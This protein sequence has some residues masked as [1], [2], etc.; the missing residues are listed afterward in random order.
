[1]NLLIDIKIMKII[2]KLNLKKKFLNLRILYKI[3]KIK[4]KNHNKKLNIKKI[5]LKKCLKLMN[6]KKIKCIIIMI[7]WKN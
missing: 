3:T 6:I 4:M 1:M 7:Y 2:Y 5:K